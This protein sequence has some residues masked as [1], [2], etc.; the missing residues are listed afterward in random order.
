[1]TWKVRESEKTKYIEKS[2]TKKAE[3]NEENRR[4]EESENGETRK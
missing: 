3:G 2:T 4:K 1:M